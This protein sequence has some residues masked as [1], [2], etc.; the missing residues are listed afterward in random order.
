[1][2]DAGDLDQRIRFERKGAGRDPVYRTPLPG[3]TEVATVWAQVQDV[4]PSRGETLSEGI[5]IAR[6][7]ARVRIRYRSGIT[8]EM[9]VI[10][11]TRVMQIV[12]GPA[13][14]GRDGLEMICEDYS[15][16]GDVA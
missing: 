10:H 8:S 12:A 13:K 1:M 15:T 9:R 3:W 14:L 11:G 5:S 2:I 6:K 16:A 7:P 4:L